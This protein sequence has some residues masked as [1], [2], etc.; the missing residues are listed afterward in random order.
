MSGM[1]EGAMSAKVIASSAKY[2][3][4]FAALGTCTCFLIAAKGVAYYFCLVRCIE[5]RVNE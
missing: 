2:S 1:I 5:M 3:S 4:F